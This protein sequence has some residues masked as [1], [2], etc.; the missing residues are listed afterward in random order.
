MPCILWLESALPSANLLE[1][2]TL[3]PCKVIEKGSVVA[4]QAGTR[5]YEQTLIGFDISK[6]DFTEIK[7]QIEDAVLFFEAISNSCFLIY[8]FLTSC[9]LLFGS[10]FKSDILLLFIDTVFL[11]SL[12]L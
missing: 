7:K 11:L 3:I 9:F 5:S 1:N 4:T 12:Y 2:I 10:F 8:F 6:A